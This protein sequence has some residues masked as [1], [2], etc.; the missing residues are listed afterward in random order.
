MQG[1]RRRNERFSSSVS[2]HLDQSRSL[3]KTLRRSETRGWDAQ[4]PISADRPFKE[5]ITPQA[6]TKRRPI[7]FAVTR[8][9]SI[10]LYGTSKMGK[11]YVLMLNERLWVSA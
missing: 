9:S 11:T 6:R 1:L 7:A 3:L 10:T 2:P 8:P 4:L 5:T